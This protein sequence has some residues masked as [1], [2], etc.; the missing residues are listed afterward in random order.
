MND[1]LD[2]SPVRSPALR[3]KP[4]GVQED[5]VQLVADAGF[6]NVVS[7]HVW[8]DVRIHG[9]NDD[10]KVVSPGQIIYC[11]AGRDLPANP[12]ARATEIMRRLAYGFHDW[13]AR[14]IVGRYHR[15][16]KRP[17]VQVP[18]K[19]I[20]ASVRIR[21]FLRSNPAATVGQIAAATGIAQP[22]VSRTISGWVEQGLAIAD[23][24]GRETRCSL[25]EP[26][27]A[28]HVSEETESLVPGMRR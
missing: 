2:L 24:D 6:R 10:F 22:N 17:S 7:T 3:H 28:S 8:P 25:I 5:F 23:R 9:G 12:T 4:A 18:A 13:A 21:R 20:P 19:T 16:L 15:D 11:I 26:V 14:E 1:V 27:T